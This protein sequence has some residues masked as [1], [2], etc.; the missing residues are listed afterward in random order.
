MRRMM[1]MILTFRGKHYQKSEPKGVHLMNLSTHRK[2]TAK[3]DD[4]GHLQFG[5]LPAGG[6]RLQTSAYKDELGCEYP[7]RDWRIR[8][9]KGE[10]LLLYRIMKSATKEFSAL[11][12]DLER[13]TPR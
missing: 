8:V 4:G 13:T 11:V 12:N 2:W 5:E 1:K 9:H 6:Y 3:T 10:R 7:A